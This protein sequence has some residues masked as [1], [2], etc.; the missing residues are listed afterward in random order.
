MTAHDTDQLDHNHAC[1][2]SFHHHRR[3]D[4]TC[5][6][7]K[8]ISRSLEFSFCCASATQNIPGIRSEESVAEKRLIREDDQAGPE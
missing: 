2:M 5:A 6:Q 7:N 1:A 4:E 8:L 3:F